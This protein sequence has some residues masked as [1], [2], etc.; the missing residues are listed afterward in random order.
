MG[1]PI[2]RGRSFSPFDGPASGSVLVISEAFASQLFPNQNALG[3][4]VVLYGR[5]R[6][7]VGVV[8]SVRYYSYD[9][10][11]QPEMYL[12]ARQ[13]MFSGMTI[14]VKTSTSDP[15]TLAATIKSEIHKIDPDQPVYRIRTMHQFV[16]ETIA[17]PRFTTLL[18][19]I[20]AGLAIALAVVGVYGVISYTVAQRSH[21]I[22]VRIALG[23]ERHQVIRMILQ[24]ALHMTAIGIVAGLVGIF[25]L[26]R[27]MAGLVFGVSVTDP[28]TLV[29]VTLLLVGV[30]LT[31]AYIPARRATRIDAMSALRI[32]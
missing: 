11:P 15:A 20:F 25:A 10:M 30:A 24:Q 27:F 19:G 21:E 12:P 28:L 9:R 7:I 1:I 31:G 6:E 14:A 4:R 2:L 3:Q 32:E 18:L 8:G 23:A 5:P 13:F 16:S 17:G 26:T 29:A 22:G